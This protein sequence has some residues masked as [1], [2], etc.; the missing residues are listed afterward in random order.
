M[1]VFIIAAV[2]MIIFVATVLFFKRRHRARKGVMNTPAANNFREG[3]AAP[4]YSSEPH[5][6]LY[7]QRGIPLQSYANNQAPSVYR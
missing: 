5:L 3:Q 6:P 4:E 2:L 7:G 1:I